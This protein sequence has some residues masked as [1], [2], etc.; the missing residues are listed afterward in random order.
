M[1]Q[2]FSDYMENA[3]LA[4]LGG[5]AMPTAPATLYVGLLT[6]LPG[7]AGSGAGT[8]ATGTSYARQTVTLGAITDSGTTKQ[9]V[10]S[11]GQTYPKTGAAESWGTAVGYQ[12]Y[13]ALTAGNPIWYGALTTPQV[14][15]P[16]TTF[17]LAV[18]QVAI[19]LD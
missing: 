1:A 9:R 19:S 8:E 7:D 11:S 5:T 17:S 6:A 15:G 2:A 13:D 10:S 4:W 3:T 18:G 14:I 16:N 12:V